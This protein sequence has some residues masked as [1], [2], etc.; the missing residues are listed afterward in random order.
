MAKKKKKKSSLTFACLA[1]SRDRALLVFIYTHLTDSST[2]ETHF[3]VLSIQ[4][5]LLLLSLVQNSPV[6]PHKEA[7]KGA[8][9]M[10]PLAAEEPQRQL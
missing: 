7:V 4:Y 1:A 5:K 3:F 9:N 8:L 2:Y 10:T 6:K